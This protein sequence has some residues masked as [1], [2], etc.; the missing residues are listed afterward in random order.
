MKS[1]GIWV[2]KLA[3]TAFTRYEYSKLQH[4]SPRR[5]LVKNFKLGIFHFTTLRKPDVIAELDWA[6]SVLQA[7]SQ[8]HDLKIV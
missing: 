1:N 3:K 5:N 8:R 4:T 7:C 6:C 2:C